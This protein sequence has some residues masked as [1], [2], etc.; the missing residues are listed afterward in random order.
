MKTV[1]N[2]AVTDLVNVADRY[3]TLNHVVL[4]EINFFQ[5][6]KVQDL[7]AYLKALM[8]EQIQFYERVSRCASVHAL[9]HT[10]H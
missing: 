3:Q 5:R 9:S 1:Q 10:L 6:E 8:D 7:N 4:A 2:R